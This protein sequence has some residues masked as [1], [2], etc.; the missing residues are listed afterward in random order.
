MTRKVALLLVMG[1]MLSMTACGSNTPES[2]YESAAKK[3]KKAD[4]VEQTLKSQ[5]TV[6]ESGSDMDTGLQGTL[7][8]QE[9]GSS[10]GT[11]AFEGNMDVDMATG[12]PMNV[13]LSYYYIEG[14]MY[15][16]MSG[17]QYK[18]KMDWEEAQ[19]QMGPGMI[20]MVQ[21]SGS[22]FQELELTEEDNQT[23]LTFSVKPEQAEKIVGA[24][25]EWSQ[26]QTIYGE[27]AQVTFQ[28]ASGSFT[29]RDGY[30]VQ[31]TLK[32]TGTVQTGGKTLSIIHDITI[33]VTSY[34]AADISLP[35]FG[36]YQEIAR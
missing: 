28:N 6:E 2:I 30:I 23:L 22:D 3:Y 16:N 1:V 17:T 9:P 29:V 4:G 24:G 5:L 25:A 15:T 27:D 36:S 19:N 35:E 33:D 18:M 14:Y 11:V 13:P 26:Y 20:L 34:Q 31:E 32:L 8:I 12:I 10:T 21:L 7:K